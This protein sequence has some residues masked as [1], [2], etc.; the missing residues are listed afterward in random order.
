LPRRPA[1]LTG[2]KSVMNCL[3]NTINNDFVQAFAHT[4]SAG[5]ANKL[6]ASNRGFV[7]TASLNSGKMQ[8]K[9]IFSIKMLRKQADEQYITASAFYHSRWGRNKQNLRWINA[10]VLDFDGDDQDPHDLAL[11]IAD[12]GLP[13]AS[14]MVRTPSGGI[15]TWW[16]LKPVRGTPK[17]IRLYESLQASLAAELGSDPAAV[18]AERL[19]RLPTNQNVIYSSKKKHKL[20]AF[21][22]W[23]DENRPADMPGQSQKG[24]VY[25]F[26]RGLLAHPGVKQLQQGVPKGQRNEACFAL[27][28][29]HLISGYSVIETE[30]I[31]LTWNQLN[32]P[33]LPEKEVLKCVASAMKGLNKDYQHYYNAMR[34]KVKNITGIEIKYRPITTVK[35]REERKRSHI[36][37]WRHD[38]IALLHKRGGKLVITQKQLASILGAPLRSVKL[39][40]NQL[41]VEGLIY[42]DSVVR[43]RKSFTVIIAKICHNCKKLMVHTGIHY[44]TGRS[45]GIKYEEIKAF[46]SV[47]GEPEFCPLLLFL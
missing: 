23:R 47:S 34:C 13:P 26:T 25:A 41:E 40:L 36:S 10:I 39:L 9:T 24:Q 18:G 33:P 19:W 37:E 44:G 21:R 20:S 28:A 35:A 14:M 12:A 16:F 4:L 32:S 31:L 38:I 27:A 1:C 3:N 8:Q 22:N 17:A 30:Q 11:K 42:R 6:P 46:A 15:H 43:G 2:A 7:F 5:T 45:K 29:A